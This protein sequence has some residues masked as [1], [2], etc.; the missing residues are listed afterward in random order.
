M[1]NIVRA[2][3]SNFKVLADIGRLTFIESHGNSASKADIDC[4]LNEKYSY[5]AFQEEL[6]NADNIYHIIYHEDQP[7]GFS[8]IVLN[9]PLPN[10]QMDN[11]T[12][13][14]RLYILKAFYQ[15]K[16]GLELF[17]FNVE[18]S[19]SSNEVG[20]W[21]FVWT[22]NE[23]A[24]NFYTKNGFQTIASHEFK[25]SPTHSNPNYQMFLNY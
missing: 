15:L 24:I 16:K 23:R 19:K 11:V 20:M 7:I 22:E 21:L 10:I 13:L 8:K 6:S 1:S 25:I 18:L 2:T 5:E 17:N 4:Y 14:E 9:S 3:K 12:K